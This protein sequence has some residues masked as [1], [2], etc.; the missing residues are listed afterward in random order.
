MRSTILFSNEAP[1]PI[2]EKVF[3][4]NSEISRLLVTFQKICEEKSH[5]GGVTIHVDEIA[6]QIAKT[7]EKLRKII[8]WKEEN[9]LRR[10]AIER[11]IKRGLVGKISNISFLKNLDLNVF[12]EEMIMELIRGGHL[13][14][15]SIPKEKIKNVKK[16]IEKY[17]FIAENTDISTSDIKK[18]INFYD[19]LM[20]IAA[21]EIEDTLCPPLEEQN[22]IETMTD[23]INQRIKILPSSSLTQ[24]EQK[25][26][27]YIATY[28]TL[29]DL[30][31]SIIS[32]NLIK[33]KY[34]EWTTPNKENLEY[35]VKN[36]F[37]IQED[38]SIQLKHPLRK[39]FFNICEKYDTIFTILE[40]I[41]KKYKD[42]PQDL[43]EIFN[44]KNKLTEL[45]TEFYNIRYKSLK[46]RLLK[47]AIFSTLS[48]FVANWFTYFLVEIPLAKLFY[49]KFNVLAAI[50]DFLVPSL[51][52][53]IIVS[54]IKPP[55]KDNLKELLSVI[56]KYVYSNNDKDIYEIK[57]R[58]KKG[59]ITRFI[60]FLLYIIGFF[61][62]F[63]TI[64]WAYY[65]ATLPITSVIFDTFTTAINV[66]AAL[67]IRNKAREITI[68]DK[69]TFGEFILDLFSLPLA[70]IG[71]WIANKWKEYNVV[72]IFLNVAVEIPIVSFISFVENWRNFVK[73]KK[74]DIH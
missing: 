27:T 57:V 33:I 16:I 61:V 42:S 30:D 48:V 58:K 5:T 63:G 69:T 64:A 10:S 67:V 43:N 32:Y 52:M 28:R 50:I 49:E 18:K 55:G 22:L 15:D 36:I 12:S 13:E 2:K 31:D 6:S 53:F 60:I 35:F 4:L 65:K 26:Q 34:N 11:I 38:L 14:N 29:Y 25:I 37:K 40:D 41:L 24:E 47:L 3:G 20:A 44:D 46:K 7:Y 62:S 1:T 21:C 59:I 68:E 56:Y 19:W 70:E 66:F 9:L 51:A 54:L 23:L 71:S 39:R 74:A 72:S 17:L 73:D 45:V 8:D